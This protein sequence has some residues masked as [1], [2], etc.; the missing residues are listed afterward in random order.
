[1]LGAL[2]QGSSTL[3]NARRLNDGVFEDRGG[4]AHAKSHIPCNRINGMHRL[5]GFEAS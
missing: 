2:F 1:M 3:A 5:L 4:G